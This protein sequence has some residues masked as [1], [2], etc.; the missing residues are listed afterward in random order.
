MRVTVRYF[1]ALREMKRAEHESVD[2]PAGCTAGEAY[3]RVCPPAELP[4]AYAVNL[5]RV[6]AGHVLHEGDE[7][8]LLPP[9]GGG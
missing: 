3:A 1:A 5:E 2:L 7:L 4:V 8:A 6:P 9:L